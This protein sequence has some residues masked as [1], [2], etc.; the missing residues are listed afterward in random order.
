LHARHNPGIGGFSFSINIAIIAS[1]SEAYL[2]DVTYLSSVSFNSIG[3]RSET[4]AWDLP[5]AF[6]T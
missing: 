6:D 2:L 5:F 4:L 3:I 1:D